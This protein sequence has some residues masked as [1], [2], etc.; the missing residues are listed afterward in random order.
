M[1]KRHHLNR[2]FNEYLTAFALAADFQLTEQLKGLIWNLF[3]PLVQSAINERANKCVK[4]QMRQNP[5][6]VVVIVLSAATIPFEEGA[7]F[8]EL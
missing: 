2:P 7:T 8:I 5:N 4:D 6:K 3:S 1:L